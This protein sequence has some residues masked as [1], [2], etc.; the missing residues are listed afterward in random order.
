MQRRKFIAAMGSLAAGGAAATGT[1]AFS[2]A[3]ANRTVS[4][5]VVGDSAAYLA[6]SRGPNEDVEEDVVTKSD[7][8]Q[9]AINLDGTGTGTENDDDDGASGLNQNATTQFANILTAEN[10]GTD[11]VIFGVDVTDIMGKS[12]IEGFDVYA[13]DDYGSPDYD[14]AV[15]QAGVGATAEVDPEGS[16]VNPKLID[17]DEGEG[18]DLSFSVETNDKTPESSDNL[19]LPF[20]AVQKGGRNDKTETDNFGQDK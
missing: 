7:D 8:G 5:D 6:L 15:F 3:Q 9:F 18:V 1:G 2:S 10:Q 12:W 4:I 11:D 13:H 14:G 20:I 19:T 17:L 16:P